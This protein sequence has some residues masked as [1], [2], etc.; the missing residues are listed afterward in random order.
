LVTQIDTAHGLVTGDKINTIGG[1]TAINVTDVAITKVD[2]D[3]FTYPVSGATN[4]TAAA[5]AAGY[6]YRVNHTSTATTGA[7][8]ILSVTAKKGVL[9][10]ATHTFGTFGF[11]PTAAGSYTMTMWHD[12]NADNVISSSEVT[13]T[14]PFVVTAAG[15]GTTEAGAGSGEATTATVTNTD[16]VGNDVLVSGLAVSFNNTPRVGQQASVATSA[17]F[18]NNRATNA[19]Y[20]MVTGKK[21]ATIVYALA[22]NST[23]QPLQGSTQAREENNIRLICASCWLPSSLVRKLLLC[24]VR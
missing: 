23:T 6:R 20:D 17:T 2:D 22:L 12:Q 4:A 21:V 16:V 8:G 19:N 13:A 3:T 18:F 7:R 9:I 11:T 5:A 15:L 1:A 14:S 24:L 10:D